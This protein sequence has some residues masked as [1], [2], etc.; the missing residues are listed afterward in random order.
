MAG[1]N[2][3]RGRPAVRR[4]VR[5]GRRAVTGGVALV[6]LGLLSFSASA[7]FQSSVSATHAT[8]TGDMSFTLGSPGD[9]HSI[10]LASTDIVPGDTITRTIEMTVDNGTDTLTGV[11]L[12]TDCNGTCTGSQTFASDATYGLRLWIER[13]DQAY[14]VTPTW[15]GSA[16]PTSVTCGGTAADVVGSSAA[17]VAFVQTNVA[18]GSALDLGDGAV[19][20]LKVRIT[21]PAGDPGDHDSMRDQSATL[22]FRFNGTQRAGTNR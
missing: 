9:S 16:I 22:R 10:S 18:I 2:T 8:D 14:D 4:P 17:P 13:C 7:T 19:N 12:T 21:W 1:E 3:T 11:T 6:A 20:H 15:D 5:R